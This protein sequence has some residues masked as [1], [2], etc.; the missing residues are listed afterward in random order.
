MTLATMI[1]SIATLLT[2]L[3]ALSV[4]LLNRWHGEHFAAAVECRKNLEAD[5]QEQDLYSFT[6]SRSNTLIGRTVGRA[7][8]AV[9]AARYDRLV[10]KHRPIA[11][12]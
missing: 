4:G 7:Y 3:A 11:A 12:A 2:L 10:R 9:A 1:I 6:A 8:I 5:G